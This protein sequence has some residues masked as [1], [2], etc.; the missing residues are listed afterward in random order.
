[1]LLCPIDFSAATP[2]VVTYAAALAAGTGA[3]LRLLHVLEAPTPQHPDEWAAAQ[4]AGY[5]ALAECAGAR[6][7]TA[8]RCGR[9]A[10]VILTEAQAWPAELLVVGAH[11]HSQLLRFLVGSTAEE[12]LRKAPCATLLVKRG[13]AEVYQQA[14]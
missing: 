7:S 6:T 8:I 3:A 4:L 14:A 1:M 2:Q 13:L 11:G 10:A 12:V 9:P 5:H